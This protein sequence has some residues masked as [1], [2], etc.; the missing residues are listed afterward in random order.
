MLELSVSRSPCMPCAMRQRMSLSERLAR[1]TW[2]KSRI[3][4]QEQH[5][6]LMNIKFA[7]TWVHMAGNE[8]IRIN[9]AWPSS[10]SLCIAL[11]V[12]P[13]RPGRMDAT[14]GD[15]RAGRPE[16]GE[17]SQGDFLFFDLSRDVSNGMLCFGTTVCQQFPEQCPKTYHSPADIPQEVENRLVQKLCTTSF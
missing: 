13:P 7:P 5:I 3:E 12:W 15:H 17:L 9:A 6:F 11:L 2:S 1:K 8:L 10:G 14:L 4:D 16:R